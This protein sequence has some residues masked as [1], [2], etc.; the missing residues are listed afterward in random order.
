MPPALLAACSERWVLRLDDTS[1]APLAGVPV[2]SA[3][4]AGPGRLVVASSGLEA[5]LAILE[6]EP[7]NP[8]A[9]GPAP[10]GTLDWEVDAADLPSGRS[11]DGEND[12]VVGIDFASLAPAVLTVTDGEHVLVAGP[13]RSGRTTA[14]LRLAA[15]WRDVHPDGT[16]HAVSP[17][18]GTALLMD[19]PTVTVD[20]VAALAPG[21]PRLIVV[22]DA[23][24]VD[25]PSGALAALV[26]ER[27]PGLLVIAAGRPD[28]LRTRYGEWTSVVRRSRTGLLLAAC[29]DIDGDLLG[30]LLPRHPPLPPRAGLAW[31]VGGGQRALVQI[32]RA[33]PSSAGLPTCRVG[34]PTRQTDPAT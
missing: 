23:D 31:L 2:A 19:S 22:D 25:D 20:A 24:R 4:R 14:L 26:A 27:R 8:S 21:R 28:A 34:S 10:V 16:V 6:I 33:T 7:G 1:E 30:E 18:P 17:R 12:L 3:P 13:P 5:Q 11:R 32:G 15:S 29:A 9:Y